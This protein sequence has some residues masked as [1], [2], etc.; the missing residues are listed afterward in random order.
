MVLAGHCTLKDCDDAGI[1]A[2]NMNTD[3]YIS[4]PAFLL[5]IRYPSRVPDGSGQIPAP[6]SRGI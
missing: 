4:V 2:T 5:D 3:K 6:Q 1:A